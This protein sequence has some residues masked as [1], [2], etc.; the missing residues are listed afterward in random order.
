[1]IMVNSKAIKI[2]MLELDI[3]TQR[4]LAKLMSMSESQLS[5]TLKR[6]RWSW[7]MLSRFC[8]ALKCQPGDI[9]VHEPD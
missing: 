8:N 2:L 7:G 4:E 6:G 1:M 3:P 9:L 5:N